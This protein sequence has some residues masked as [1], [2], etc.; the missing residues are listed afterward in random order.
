MVNIW[1]RGRL[2]VTGRIKRT[3]VLLLV[4]EMLEEVAAEWLEV[5]LEEE[6]EEQED[7]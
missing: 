5:C 6:E 4:L 2:G 7:L 3:T 1:V